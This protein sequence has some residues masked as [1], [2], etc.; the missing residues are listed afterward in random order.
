MA[1]AF[2][3]AVQAGSSELVLIE[4]PGGKSFRE[5]SELVE[6]KD[7]VRYGRALELL[8]RF[9]RVDTSKVKAGEYQLSPGMTPREVLAKLVSGETV[10]RQIVFKDGQTI[11]ELGD[12]LEQAGI[13]T[14][15]EF[16]PVLSEKGALAKAGIT[17]ESFEGYLFPESYEFT[18]PVTPEQIVWRMMEKGEERWKDEYSIRAEALQ[19]SRHEILTLASMIQKEALNAEDQAKISS[20]F[21]NRMKAGMRL[22]SDPTVGYGIQNFSGTVT[23]DDQLTDHAWNTYTRFGLPIGPICNPGQTA[24]HA[25]LFPEDTQYLFFVSDGLGGHVFSTTLQEHNDAVSRFQAA[26]K[27]V[28]P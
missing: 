4:I 11:F 17:A 26:A 9:T 13:L 2:L 23:K 14:R 18:R 3:E 10:K 21:H 12:L 16:E 1:R 5:V 24:V 28:A 22:Q 19:M 8:A 27:P 20:V 15:Q 7:I 6:S 25:A